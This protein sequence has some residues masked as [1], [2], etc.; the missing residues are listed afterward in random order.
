MWLFNLKDPLSKLA[1]W[2]IYLEDYNYEIKYKPGVLNSNVDALSRIYSIQE[3]EEESYSTFLEK[4][5]TKLITNSN[6]KEVSGIL[7]ESPSEYHIVSEIAKQYNFMS[8]INYE[9]KHKF[10]RDQT[11]KPS[12]SV[13]EINYFKADDRYIIFIVTKNKNKQVSTYENM[14]VS[15]LNLKTFCETHSLN[16]IAMNKMGR[17]DNLEWSQVRAM[18]R[19]IFRKINIEIM[20]CS[21]SELSENDKKIIL[22]QYHDSK[23][24]GHLGINKTVK[25]VKTQFQWKGMK[26]DIKHYIKHCEVCQ[27]NKVTNQK[28]QQPMVITSTSS[29]PFKKISLDIVGPLITTLRGNN[30]ILTMQDDLT[31]YSLG[32]ALLDHRA[33][34]VA[35]VFVTHF[36]CVHG[37]PSS[38]LTDQGTEFLS[39]TFTAVCKLLNINKLKTSPFHPQTNGGLERSHRTLSEYLRSFVNQKLNNWDDLLPY[40]FFVYNS[41][42][43]TSTKFQPY[44]LLYGHTLHIPNKLKREPEP[45]Y[46][47]DDYLF[48]LKQKMQESF[49]LAR[50]N[51]IK[52]KIQSK[53]NYDSKENS[54]ELQIGDQILLRDNTQ[55]NKLN[56]L[57]T[58]PYQ[59]IRVLNNE[60]IVIQRGKN[61]VTIHKNNVKKYYNK[62]D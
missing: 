40:A 19:Y 32:V 38:I 13:G 16:K 3:I 22:E 36:V 39:N 11:L 8:G 25:K 55:K 34:T 59:V 44:K 49:Q 5:K 23:L 35:E 6:I 56:A 10:G 45:R 61:Q 57:W 42:E 50:E 7:I 20:I 48:D 62:Q 9:L 28:V 15:L 26:E 2:R 33:N 47:Y 21:A 41:T 52:K 14:Y 30:Y 51:L 1:R 58:G 54:I 18:I 29:R 12:T 43:H 4:F 53:D 31:K 17:D 60:N 37:L 46:N 27:K 24:G